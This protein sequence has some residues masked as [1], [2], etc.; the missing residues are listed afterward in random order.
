[1]KNIIKTQEV[2]TVMKFGNDN[3]DRSYDWSHIILTQ[4]F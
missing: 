3:S 2:I 4:T 1:M